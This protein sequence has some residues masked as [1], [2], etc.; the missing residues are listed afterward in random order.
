MALEKVELPL[1]LGSGIDTGTDPK[2]VKPGSLLVLENA[3]LDKKTG[4]IAKR[5]GNTAMSLD[6][7]NDSSDLSGVLK[8]TTRD[9]ELVAI[10]KDAVY[11][12][13]ETRS[14]WQWKGYFG[15]VTSDATDSRVDASSATRLCAATG[16]NL[17]VLVFLD[18]QIR[19]QIEDMFGTIL[20]T[21]SFTATGNP[22]RIIYVDS[23]F[24]VFAGTVVYKFSTSDYTNLVGPHTVGYNVFEVTLADDQIVAV[25]IGSPNTTVFYCQKGIVASGG[26]SGGIAEGLPGDPYTFAAVSNAAKILANSNT[27]VLGVVDGA[28]DVF[29][30]FSIPFALGTNS[31]LGSVVNNF[32]AVSIASV[33]DASYISGA[34]NGNLV[35]WALGWTISGSPAQSFVS[36]VET[37]INFATT[38]SIV[39]SSTISSSHLNSDPFIDLSGNVYFNVFSNTS[40]KYDGPLV[41]YRMF[42][43]KNV[44]NQKIALPVNAALINTGAILNQ[45]Q[46]SNVISLGNNVFKVIAQSTYSTV[47]G[48]SASGVNFIYK[49]VSVTLTIN[50]K[51]A[52]ASFEK[53]GVVYFASGQLMQYDGNLTSNVGFLDLPNIETITDRAA[54][55]PEPG[56]VA[57]TYFFVA[58]Y[59]WIDSK[60]NIHRGPISDVANITTGST[61]T[62]ELN[63]VSPISSSYTKT[64]GAGA[65]L[66]YP[67]I[68]GSRI[69]FHKT[70]SG[71]AVFYKQ[72]SSQ[73]PSSSGNLLYTENGFV[74]KTL[75]NG[76]DANLTSNEI[77]YTS[78]GEIEAVQP[79][80]F[81]H[82]CE[83]NGRLVLSNGDD[84]NLIVY[85]KQKVDTVTYE[86]NRLFSFTVPTDTGRS[87]AA[88]ALDDK[89]IIFT[90]NALFLQAGQGPSANGQ[91]SDFASVPQ[92]IS[93]DVGCLVPK[94]IVSYQDGLIWFTSKGFYK[95]D[96]SLGLSYVGKAVE[97]YNHLDFREGILLYDRREIRWVSSNGA[98]V[99][100]DYHND[101][102]Y[103][104]TNHEAV[105]CCL[106]NDKF[107]IAKTNGSIWI[108]NKS[109][110]LDDGIAYS[111]RIVTPWFSLAGLQHAQRLYRLNILGEL[112]SPHK[113]KIYLAYDYEPARREL[114]EWDS[115]ANLGSVSMPDGAYYSTPSTFTTENRTYDIEFRP[116]IQKCESFR[117]E[118]YDENSTSSGSPIDG[119]CA[120]LTSMTAVVGV[121]QATQKQ[122]ASRRGSS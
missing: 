99:V 113:L 15:C 34:I 100:Y 24:Y 9:G 12:Y 60:G 20:Y 57:G 84:G 54:V 26:T 81:R 39:K 91:N 37:N 59:Q 120:L 44:A 8:V 119:E 40:R 122:N 14:K 42:E 51:N 106:Y 80:S 29:N 69:V 117:L 23:V 10:T 17:I 38:G 96:R 85:S 70:T 27:I 79:G 43:D 62:I 92:K 78:G 93:S 45:S 3:N 22:P 111:R 102:W 33:G 16:G 64:D 7:D 105:S 49:L 58:S 32:N 1:P 6:I 95:L 103:T 46:F 82:L 77:L 110:Y 55:S 108:E 72:N 47:S 30:I 107:V 52:L 76:N 31:S 2:L 114:M 63:N 67:K 65:S 36:Y 4:S 118:I 35:Y 97:E 13:S 53:D 88:K 101:M 11:S 50:D 48:T 98:C 89:L 75:I 21:H 104:F 116:A 83:Y 66:A 28:S 61:R 5:Y 73:S 68:N 74:F 19:I 25:D 109:S 121:K 41:T 115:S 56:V 112:K 86:F 90:E 87:V 18:V 94:T 71:G